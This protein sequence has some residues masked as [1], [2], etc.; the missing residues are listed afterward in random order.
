MRLVSEAVLLLSNH[1]TSWQVTMLC[2]R[3]CCV[4]ES[5][6]HMRVQRGLWWE[7]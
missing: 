3:R 5:L 6:E 1:V 2:L 7:G 4:E